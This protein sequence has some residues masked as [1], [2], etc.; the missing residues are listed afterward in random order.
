[1]RNV[2]PRWAAKNLWAVNSQEIF[3]FSF[4]HIPKNGVGCHCQ[5]K[6][7]LMSTLWKLKPR[8]SLWQRSISPQRQIFE[9][10]LPVYHIWL[11]VLRGFPTFWLNIFVLSCIH[12]DL[13]KNFEIGPFHTI[14]VCSETF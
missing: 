14:K 12:T 9:I 1:M 8:G 13:V 11:V 3:P 5:L 2:G 7:S 4:G 6:K 10:P